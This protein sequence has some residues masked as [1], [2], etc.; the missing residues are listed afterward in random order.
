MAVQGESVEAWNL[1]EVYIGNVRGSP[2]SNVCFGSTCL[3]VCLFTFKFGDAGMS[4]FSRIGLKGRDLMWK[5][6]CTTSFNKPDGV[7][8]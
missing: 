7:H 6:Y 2:R 4:T 8:E 1:R 5:S 3:I